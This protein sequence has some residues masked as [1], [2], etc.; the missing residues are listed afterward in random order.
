VSN[1]KHLEAKYVNSR[2]V[3][4]F[5]PFFPPAMS[6][7]QEEFQDK[8]Q[9]FSAMLYDDIADRLRGGKTTPLPVTSDVKKRILSPWAYAIGFERHKRRYLI[10]MP[11]PEDPARSGGN[12]ATRHV[13][14]YVRGNELPAVGEIEQVAEEFANIFVEILQRYKAQ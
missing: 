11:K 10:L 6:K 2:A 12:F 7:I 9:R 14:L 1:E 5:G 8:P 4:F 13:A 3:K